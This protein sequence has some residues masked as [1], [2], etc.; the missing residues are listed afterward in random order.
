MNKLINYKPFYFLCFLIIGIIIQFYTKIWKHQ[1]LTLFLF[2]L[3]FFLLLVLFYTLQKKVAFTITSF[4]GFIFIGLFTTFITNPRNQKNYYAKMNKEDSTILLQ[5]HKVLKSNTYYNSYEADVIQ[6]D[7]HKT[8]GKILL[9]IS[10]DSTITSLKVHQNLFTKGSFKEISHPLNPYAFDYKNYLI[11]QGIEHQIH[12]NTNEY[13]LIKNDIFSFRKKLIAFRTKI[14]T[15]LKQQNF[16]KDELAIINAILLGQKQTLSNNLK[17]DYAKA[18]AIHILAISGLHIGIL[19]ALLTQLFLP[20]KSLK[21]GPL[22]SSL[23]IISSLWLFALFTGL[24]ASVV[25]ATTMFTFICIGNMFQKKKVIEH[26]LITSMFFILLLKPLFLF[27]VG[28]Q[29]SY[30]AVFGIV[31]IKPLFYKLWEPKYFLVDKVWQLIT[32]SLAAQIGVLPISL[33]YFHQFPG[34]FLLANSIIIPLLGILLSGGFIIIILMLL[35][36]LPDFLVTA[37]HYLILLIN[38]FIHRVSLQEAFLFTHISMSFLKMIAFYVFIIFSF[39]F[40][41]RKKTKPLIL[42]LTSIIW[43]QG[44]Y[45][46]EKYNSQTT[47]ELIVFHK[48]MHSLIGIKKR[49]IFDVFYNSDNFDIS[50]DNSI[51][52][53]SI[54][55]NISTTVYHQHKKI[56]QFDKTLILCI[57]SLGIYNI[58]GVTKP[59]VILQNSPK[60]NLERNL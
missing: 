23:L 19:L 33:Y 51:N 31:W 10:K 4:F 13:F 14:Q 11:K 16:T 57:D 30:L 27:D 50:K 1:L 42:V 6:I 58:K 55:N 35:N 22:I 26:S 21:N 18:G 41:K 40:L 56:Y 60:I 25:R 36:I 32:V 9:K 17:E 12:L 49:N 37:Y 29:L 44:I 2:L 3:V 59:I 53:Y 38:T 20:L 24:S 28:F 43:I 46:Y 8:S 54:K 34:L 7:N 47:S 52:N 15:L 45:L 48:N 39:Q 5:I